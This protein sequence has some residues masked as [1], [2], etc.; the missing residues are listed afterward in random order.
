VAQVIV[1][2]LDNAIRFTPRGG[3]VTLR[4]SQ[5]SLY[6]VLEVRDTGIGIPAEA[7]PNVFDRFFRVDEARSP[8]DGAPDL[9]PIAQGK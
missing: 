3:T 2:L 1:N 8:E 7:L 6:S 5:S 9:A 4:C